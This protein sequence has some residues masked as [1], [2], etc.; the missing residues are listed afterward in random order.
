MIQGIEK[1]EILGILTE[2]AYCLEET[3]MNLHESMIGFTETLCIA[4]NSH[5]EKTS[6]LLDMVEGKLSKAKNAPVQTKND[7]NSLTLELSF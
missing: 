7:P 6:M 3:E 4:H 2:M 5:L 1:E